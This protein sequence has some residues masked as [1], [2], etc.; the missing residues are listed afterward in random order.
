[1]SRHRMTRRDFLQLA[2]VAAAAGSLPPMAAGAA[3]PAAATP[4]KGGVY[5]VGRARTPSFFD[6][7]FLAI[8]GSPNKGTY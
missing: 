5:V 6:C 1:M 4:K 2:T 3:Q 7:D 8:S